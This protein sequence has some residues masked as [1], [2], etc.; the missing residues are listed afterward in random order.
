MALDVVSRD[1]RQS[2]DVSSWTGEQIVLNYTNGTQLTYTFDLSA[3][4]L[5][6]TLAGETKTMLTEVDSGRFSVFQRNPVSGSY[7]QYPVGSPGTTKLVQ[8]DWQCSRQILKARIN[9]ESV[10]SAKIVIRR[11]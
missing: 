7:D 4:T 2:T 5:R 10:Q 6:R 11:Q 3:R 8:V 1:I 9:T